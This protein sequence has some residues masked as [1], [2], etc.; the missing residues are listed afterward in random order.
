MLPKDLSLYLIVDPI[1]CGGHQQCVRLL[2]NV[3]PCGVNI[4]QLRAP[5]WHKGAIYVLAKEL[6]A[7]T[8]PNGIPLIINDHVDVSLAAGADGVHLGANDLPPEAA[9]ELLGPDAI[10]GYSV[11]NYAQLERATRLGNKIDYLGVGPVFST[12]TKPDHAPPIGIQKLRAICSRSV[13]PTVAIGGINAQKADEIMAVGAPDGLAV[14]S[15]ICGTE[16]P[17]KAAR[18][19]RE[20]IE[21][22]REMRKMLQKLK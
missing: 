16:E 19:L 12:P 15:A 9:R 17:A 2:N 8:R 5:K 1:L 22:G 7:I 10:V 11:S 14:I 18:E 4:V 3:I 13:H 21:K 6:L 20:A